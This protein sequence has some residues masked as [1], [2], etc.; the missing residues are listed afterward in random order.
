MMMLL[1]N[2]YELS[3]FT[4]YSSKPVGRTPQTALIAGGVEILEIM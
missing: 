2:R 3:L 1:C 4:G